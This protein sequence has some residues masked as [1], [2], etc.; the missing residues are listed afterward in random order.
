MARRFRKRSPV[1]VRRVDV[2][3][4]LSNRGKL[5]SRNLECDCE[6]KCLDESP[7]EAGDT[8]KQVQ[9][10]MKSTVGTKPEG[11]QARCEIQRARELVRAAYAQR[12]R[13]RQERLEAKEKLR[14]LR[15]QLNGEIR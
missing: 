4:L 14:S 8:L 3:I 15:D 9:Q 1:N 10:G 7:V 2:L 6:M 11:G 12:R 13:R 5:F